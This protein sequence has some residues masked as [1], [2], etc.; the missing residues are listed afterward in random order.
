MPIL[1]VVALSWKTVDRRFG[2]VVSTSYIL[3]PPVDFDLLITLYVP[4]MKPYREV[5]WITGPLRQLFREKHV[6]NKVRQKCTGLVRVCQMD[7]P[8]W[9]R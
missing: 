3:L 6:N 7:D 2:V 9:S 8:P 4:R 1:T 5:K